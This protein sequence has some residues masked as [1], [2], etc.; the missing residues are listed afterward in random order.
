MIHEQFIPPVMEQDYS[1]SKPNLHRF[2]V[3]QA[4][5]HL[6]VMHKA[7]KKLWDFSNLNCH[8]AA[9]GLQQAIRNLIYTN[10][11]YRDAAAMLFCGT[12]PTPDL[13]FEP[14]ECQK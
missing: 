13:D 3:R 10:A 7:E 5:E 9:L 11:A 12:K 14:A 8:E 1:Q 6:R 4:Y 2:Y